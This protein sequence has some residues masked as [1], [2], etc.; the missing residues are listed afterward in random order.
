M[1][2]TE[3]I[4][5]WKSGLNKELLAKIYRREYNQ[6]IKIIRANVRHRHDGRYITNFEALKYVENVIYKYLKENMKIK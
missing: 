4:K 2:D 5:K 1:K 3:I 6:G